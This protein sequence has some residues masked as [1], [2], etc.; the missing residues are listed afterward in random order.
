MSRISDAMLETVLEECNDYGGVEFTEEQ[1][2][3]LKTI[4]DRWEDR[5]SI[6]SEINLFLLRLGYTQ[7]DEHCYFFKLE[8]TYSG[9]ADFVKNCDADI[10]GLAVDILNKHFKLEGEDILTTD[11][12]FEEGLSG[13]LECDSEIIK[14]I[15]K[16]LTPDFDVIEVPV[17]KDDVEFEV[18]HKSVKIDEQTKYLESR[19]LKVI[20]PSKK[21]KGKKFVYYI[22]NTRQ[23]D[24]ES[25]EKY[26]NEIDADDDIM[27]YVEDQ[28][29]TELHG[30]CEEENDQGFWFYSGCMVCSVLQAIEI[31]EDDYNILKKYV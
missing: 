10:E 1:L 27:E 11:N 25:S 19:D 24:V 12:L 6:E 17:G 31:P 23:G 9:D 16:E 29:R 14:L 26:C 7:H 30:E 4:C 8:G 2:E 22:V 15:V 3:E 20:T 5:D 13:A 21:T 28:I 18:Q